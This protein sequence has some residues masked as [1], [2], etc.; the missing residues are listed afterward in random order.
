[1]EPNELGDGLAGF[2]GRGAGTDAE[3]RAA[4][5]LAER[6]SSDGQSVVTVDGALQFALLMADAIDAALGELQGRR[7]ATPA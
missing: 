3:R 2:A 1:M 6:L 5:W 7:A 4:H